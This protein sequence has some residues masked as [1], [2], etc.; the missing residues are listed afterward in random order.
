MPLSPGSRLGPYEILSPIGAGGMGEVYRAKD[1]RLERTVAI[2]VLPQHRS[3]SPDVR[4][5]FEREA[6]TISQLSHPHICAIYDVG[7]E[8]ETEY[9]VMEYLE[10][11]TLSD[12]LGKG[13][14]SLEQTLRLGTE[15]ADAL[16]AA[17]RQ[18]IV[19]RDLKPGNVMLTKTGVKLLDFGL[20]KVLAPA[21][22][23]SVL[24][25]L[26][27]ET[28][29]TEEGTV[30]GTVQYM[31]PEQLEGKEA[32]ARTDI[33]ALG[34]VLYEMAAGKRAFSGATRASLIGAILHTEPPAISTLQPMSPHALDRVVKTCLARDPEERWQTARDVALQ[35]KG[36][37][38]ERSEA[39]PEEAV[40]ARRR[41]SAA[42][43]WAVAAVAVAIAVFAVA[44]ALRP[45]PRPRV[46]QSFLVPP[47]G[48]TF[49]VYGANV[50]GVAV[51]PDGRRLAFGTR[52][53]D[54]SSRLWVRDLDV[55][56]SY[57]VPGGQGALFPFWSPDS[58]SIG[59][60]AKGKLKIVEA[61]VSA[62]PPRELADV[63]E[64]RGGSWGDGGMILYAT[65]PFSPLMRVASSGGTPVPAT[66]LDRASGE[67]AH[68]WPQFLP[69]GRRFLYEVRRAGPAEAPLSGAHAIFAGSLDGGLK[70]PILAEDTSAAYAP[71]G[72]LL[73]RRG[74]NLMAVAFDL[75]SL[76]LRGEPVVLASD[77]EGFVATG[78]ATFSVSDD[79]LA[80]SPRVG[81]TPAKI[82][83]LDRSGREIST[84]GPPGQLVYMGLSPDGRSVVAVRIED[85]L[86]PDL[87]SFDT[88]DGRGLRL[89]RD[90]IAQVGPIFSSDGRRIFFS[91]NS[92]GAW[93]LQEI[94]PQSGGDPKLF[95]ES[96]ST[97]IANGVSPDGRWLL[98]REFNPGTRGD[99]RVVALE[100]D[101]KPRTY[102]GTVDD[103]SNGSF[104]PDGR[105]VA[106][107]SDESGRKE[108]YAASFPDP[109]RRFRVSAEGGSQP[110][111]GR[112]GKELFYVRSGQL[113]AVS[114][115]RK[116][117]DLAFGESRPLFALPLLAMNDPGFDQLTRYDVAPDGRFL[118]LL[119]AGEETP[120]PFVLVLNWQ[121][122]LKK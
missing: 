85:P 45:K 8:G 115:G 74:S 120:T 48:T 96:G 91:S 100:G 59:F 82:A 70:R 77:I 25:A 78:A 63:A 121:E 39:R 55:L 76:T 117:D 94:S 122:L 97:K 11:E 46:T 26:P 52:E 113:L 90:A 64:P 7:R 61:S 86:P 29:L 112:D 20:A 87:W 19:H 36:I 44:P 15:I 73:F 107:A 58:R 17:H 27:T 10:G 83:W 43:P 57:P 105:W 81:A 60:F 54:G 116:G 4:Q 40:P 12:R 109:S 18:G 13:A 92:K 33:F 53:A 41:R 119:R 103:E 89:T 66:S 108:V 30:L 95:L 80:Y 31:A 24:T 56:M 21:S 42:L 23:A 1:T 14:L 5:R 28:P 104:S 35:L 118:A 93:N 67:I 75:K 106:Y 98:Y 3:S 50:A 49:H 16:E 79:V 65:A 37:E 99:L 9:L 84:V 68:R 62:A 51:S 114:V 6:K 2:K 69:D 88:A 47:A 72:Y 32:D 22:S 71:P 101:R 102:I 38:Q 110:R 34:C 111:W